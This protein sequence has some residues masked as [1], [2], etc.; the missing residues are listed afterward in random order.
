MNPIRLLLADDHEL[1]RAG[2]CSLLKD[3]ADVTVVAE[4]ATGR[5]ALRLVEQ[6]RPDIVLMDIMMPELNGLDAAARIVAH[7]PTVRIIILSMNDS[8]EYVLQALR[9]GATG[10]VLKNVKPAELEE[11]IRTVARGETYLTASVSKHV[12]S[13]YLQQASKTSQTANQ[14]TP[15]QR[16]VLQFIAEGKTTKEIARRL[17]ISVKTVEGHRAQLMQALD[18]H[19]VAGLVRYAIRM[20][21]IT[22]GE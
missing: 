12:V 7:Y 20:G 18:I 17:G 14:L 16:E 3:V 22:A 4:A 13:G 10:Y 11:A 19:E 15:R 1:V 5:E 6:H 8:E 9:A 21:I 2:F